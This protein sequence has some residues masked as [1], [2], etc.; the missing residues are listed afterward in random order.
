MRG[1]ET[2]VLALYINF[3]FWNLGLKQAKQMTYCWAAAFTLDCKNYER[4]SLL[5][6]LQI[7]VKIKIEM[8]L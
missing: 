1:Q 3:F 8:V 7:S 6:N 4:V 2:C 5:L